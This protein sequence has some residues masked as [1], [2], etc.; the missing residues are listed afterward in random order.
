MSH[1][2]TDERLRSA[3][4]AL[5]QS[6]AVEGPPGDDGQ[7]SVW[8]L[9][10]LGVE[11]LSLVDESGQVQRQELTLLEDH[12]MWASGK[13]LSTG[14]VE[15]AAPISSADS[16]VVH[17]DERP[18]PTRLL[19]A[20]LALEG[21][22]GQ[23]RYILHM[24]RVL[25]LARQGLVL[26][27]GQAPRPAPVA[28]APE[29]PSPQAQA[30]APSAPAAPLVTAAPPAPVPAASQ[31][32]AAPTPQREHEGLIMLVVMALGAVVGLALLAL[33]V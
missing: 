3:V 8:H 19:R 26:S 20:A 33:L 15:R 9:S 27:G 14:R 18:M 11:L 4:Q 2:P 30:P 13:G 1:V 31:A 29:A 25:A 17:A 32:T 16:A 6:H 7:R 10:S 24:Q 23:D 21:Y 12:C 5:F 22:R 28:A